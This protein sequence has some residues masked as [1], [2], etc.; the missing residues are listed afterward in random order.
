MRR[1]SGAISRGAAV[2]L[3]IAMATAAPAGAADVLDLLPAEVQGAVV[4]K[5]L[6]RLFAVFEIEAVRADNPSA[7][8]QFSADLLAETGYDPATLDGWRDAGF[9]VARPFAIGVAEGEA[10]YT[11]LLLPGGD[12]ALQ[13]VRRIMAGEGE[14]V[15]ATKHGGVE[16]WTVEDVA[17]VLAH[18]EY[19]AIVATEENGAVAAAA[20]YLDQL[21][22]RRLTADDRFKRVAK[23]LDADADLRGYLGPDLYRAIFGHGET[24]RVAALGLTEEETEALYRKWGVDDASGV[25][26]ANFAPDGIRGQGT[27]WIRPGSPVFEWYKLDND[28][29]AFLR[30]TPAD[31]WLIS[32]SRIN[33]ARAWRALRDAIPEPPADSLSLDERLAKASETLHIDVERELIEQI[34]GNFLVLVNRAAPMDADAALVVQVNDP[35]RFRETLARVIA[36]SGSG[37][38]EDVSSVV[39]DDV[40]GIPYYRSLVP[41]V[42]ELCMGVIDDHFVMTLSRERFISIAQGGDGFATTLPVKS[43]QSAAADPTAGAFYVDFKSLF[44]D[45]Q[46]ILPMFGHGDDEALLLLRELSH[47]AAVSRIGNGKTSSEFELV[48]TRAGFWR[49]LLERVAVKEEAPLH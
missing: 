27:G 38:E 1:A 25:M 3:L 24:E 31:P 33:F 6:D 8:S 47:F 5:S 15:H 13:T 42:G 18:K 46:G 44:A 40:D 39:E 7:F 22:K 30:R 14:K 10:T 49:R 23:G 9:D 29:V 20:H 48:A 4:V 17:A 43:I 32:L 36:E 11:V 37:G 28:P 2:A 12:A 45:L 21:G 41:A 34:D 26:S 16:I 35:Q 19:V